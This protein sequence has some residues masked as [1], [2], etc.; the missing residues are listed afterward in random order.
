MRFKARAMHYSNRQ[1]LLSAHTLP[2]RSRPVTQ[3]TQCIMAMI[4]IFKYKPFPYYRQ[5]SLPLSRLRGK[6]QAV[7]TRSRLFIWAALAV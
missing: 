7:P 2:L 5:A 4:K 3:Y 6:F 1:T